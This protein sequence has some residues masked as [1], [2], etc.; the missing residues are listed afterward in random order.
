MDIPSRALVWLAIG[1]MA[2]V[3]MLGMFMKIKEAI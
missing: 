3:I 1:V 2:V